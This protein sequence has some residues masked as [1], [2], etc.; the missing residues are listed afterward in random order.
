ME[1][2]YL[3]I[4]IGAFVLCFL[5]TSA[6]FLRLKMPSL[7]GYIFLGLLGRF[8]ADQF[9]WGGDEFTFTI[10]LL[11]K[12]GVT[13]LLF[14]IGIETNLNKML[15]VILKA[16][17]V[18]FC[19]VVVSGFCVFFAAYI[20]GLDFWVSLVLGIAM[21]ATGIGV[22]VS[23]W[24]ERDLQGKKE[25][26]FLLD[27]ASMDDIIAILLFSLL[28]ALLGGGHLEEE[29]LAWNLLFFFLKLSAL[30][31]GCYL[32]SHFAEKKIMTEL[33]RYEKMPD[34]MLSVVGIGMIIA[35]I[36]SLLG[37]SLIIGGFFAGIA[38]S[39][40]PR[41][42]RIDASM[43]TLLDFFAPFFFFWI[44]YQITLDFAVDTWYLF[45]LILIAAVAGKLLGVWVPA[46]LIGITSMG[47]LL[48]SLSMIPRAEVTMVVLSHG[49]EL[50]WLSE[51]VY[52]AG[53]F[54]VLATSL[55]G[56]FFI[57]GLLKKNSAIGGQ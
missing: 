36:A 51:K 49:L 39:R 21:T 6:L 5:G 48:L 23:S 27:L 31:A 57:R 15:A 12:I 42:V 56:S 4:V 14:H 43:K 29:F 53:A 7:I 38:F 17:F 8:L 13:L 47:A 41:S 9:D 34:S 52:N 54:V 44:G 32:F 45:F 10:G 46:R 19:E 2:A 20:F 18:S 28:T 3:I 1:Y 40:D 33:I 35:G 26:A 55:I 37:F 30:I 50:G 11:A 16:G 24:S 22:T 25:G